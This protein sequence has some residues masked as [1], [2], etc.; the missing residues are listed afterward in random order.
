MALLTY[1][2]GCHPFACSNRT[3]GSVRVLNGTINFADYSVW[4]VGKGFGVGGDAGG[5]LCALN[6]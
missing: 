2:G 3:L 1:G 5:K 4:V 6:V